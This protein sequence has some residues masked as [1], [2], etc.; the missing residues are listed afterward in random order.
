M[1]RLP[2]SLLLS[3]LAFK[4]SF[5]ATYPRMVLHFSN[6]KANEVALY[7]IRVLLEKKGYKILEYA[8]EESFLF[9]DFNEYNWG[10]GRRFISLSVQ[11]N[12]KIT[13]T[14]TG[15]M[16]VP[17]ASIGKKSELQKIKEFDRLPYNIQKKTFLT[18]IEPLDSL[19]FK[20]IKHW[21]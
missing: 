16:D 5:C 21:P 2:I 13:I 4:F 7:D 10:G 14:G 6:N 11:I 3:F 9:T 15:K 17:V 8:P 20:Q 1:I 19:G 18:L 12:D